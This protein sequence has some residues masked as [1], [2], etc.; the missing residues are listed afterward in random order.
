MT[1]HCVPPW[2][3]L[4]RDRATPDFDGPSPLTLA[5]NNPYTPENLL[6]HRALECSSLLNELLVRT[7]SLVVLNILSPV[8]PIICSLCETGSN[9]LHPHQTSRSCGVAIGAIQN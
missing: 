7:R 3:R 8:R 1:S 4:S 2:F 5:Q 9:V 6:V